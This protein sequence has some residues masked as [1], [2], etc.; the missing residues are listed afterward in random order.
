MDFFSA[1]HVDARAI[2]ADIRARSRY[3]KPTMSMKRGI[4]RSMRDLF[5][6]GTV[7]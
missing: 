7:F 3:E 6:E 2:V 1:P 4:A 5:A